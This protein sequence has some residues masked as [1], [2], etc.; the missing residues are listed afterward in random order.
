MKFILIVDSSTSP[1]GTFPLQNL[2]GATSLFFLIPLSPNNLTVKCQDYRTHKKPIFNALCSLQEQELRESSP[3]LACLRIFMK[4]TYLV[5]MIKCQFGSLNLAR[6]SP[7]RLLFSV[8]SFIAIKLQMLKLQ[9]GIYSSHALFD[10][11]RKFFL[12]VL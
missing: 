5:A 7:V 6:F 3:R 12:L 11:H 2:D 4:A 10:V 9:C 8:F 1:A